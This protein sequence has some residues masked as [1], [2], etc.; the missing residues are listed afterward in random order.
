MS[1]DR[2]IYTEA[3][4][5]AAGH[6]TADL[7]LPKKRRVIAAGE[8]IAKRE[9]GNTIVALAH[10]ASWHVRQEFQFAPP[11]RWRADWAIAPL[12]SF[13]VRGMQV[14]LI[15]FEGGEWAWTQGDDAG[16]HQA[17]RFALDAEKY[18][19]AS[20]LGYTLLRFTASMVASGLAA[21]QIGRAI[22]GDG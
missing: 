4:L 7:S 3:E 14:I 22:S 15:E 21:D 8:S 20:I 5:L 1:E 17:Q 9:L 18:N 12:E 16:Y 19:E 13:D 10:N 2:H 6:T 11:R